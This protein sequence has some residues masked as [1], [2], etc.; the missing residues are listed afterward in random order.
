M[1]KTY[2]KKDTFKIKKPVAGFS[3]IT[4][5]KIGG[6][7]TYTLDIRT[8]F[9]ELQGKVIDHIVFNGVLFKR[10]EKQ[11]VMPL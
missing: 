7:T 11:N 10:A 5:I 1:G 6:V 3:G 4:N 8:D 9:K 2:I